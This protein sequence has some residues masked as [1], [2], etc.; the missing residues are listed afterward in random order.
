MLMP[1]RVA[2][3]R[4]IPFGLTF[5]E[6][7]V[8]R[9]LA[10]EGLN[11]ESLAAGLH[12]SEGSVKAC[13][14]SAMLKARVANRTELVLAWQ[15]ATGQLV[16]P[17]RVAELEQQV[18]LLATA[19]DR[20]RREDPPGDD[21]YRLAATDPVLAGRQPD[22]AAVHASA[23]LVRAGLIGAGGTVTTSVDQGES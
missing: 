8:V 7:D 17:G 11:N 23:A 21:D 13:V 1:A 15:R 5:R 18:H 6:R 10:D 14:T 4:G 16:G 12:I 22:D 3:A 9:L 19:L 20:I 2:P